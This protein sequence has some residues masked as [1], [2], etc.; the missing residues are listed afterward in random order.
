[1][2]DSYNNCI[3][4]I[5]ISSKQ[6]ARLNVA[7]N[8]S[9]A[10]L[11]EPN[12]ISLDHANGLLYIADTNNHSIK[13]IKN[14]NIENAQMEMEHFQIDFGSPIE[15]QELVDGVQMCQLNE[16]GNVLVRFNFKLNMNAENVCQVK[17]KYSNGS[18]SNFVD[19]FTKNNLLATNDTFQVFRLTNVSILL[20]FSEVDFL[21]M[22][23]SV[24]YCEDHSSSS[25]SYN[26]SLCKFF[27]KKLLFN[28]NE[29]T[30]NDSYLKNSILIET[31]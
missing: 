9:S 3:K 29:L 4:K 6:C 25:S 16:T 18:E 31:S 5:D 13:V 21:E 7:E 8:A 28:K 17:V 22:T 14:F 11:N 26:Q 30:F 27:K 19:S 20:G 1:V 12:G 2:A 15:S 10:S 23:L 24:V